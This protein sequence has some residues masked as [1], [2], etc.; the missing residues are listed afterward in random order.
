MNRTSIG[1]ALMTA[2]ALV[3]LIVATAGP[4]AAFKVDRCSEHAA[5]CMARC[6]LKCDGDLTKAGCIELCESACFDAF[7]KCAINAPMP[8]GSAN[9]NTPP[10]DPTGTPLKGGLKP[11]TGGGIK[12]PG[13][14][15]S[16]PPKPIVGLEPINPSGPQKSGDGG[17]GPGPTTIYRTHGK[18]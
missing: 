9:T 10:T 7:N 13:S 11:I 4:A 2:A 14:G 17:S 16:S 1:I 6:D 18:R 5:Q 8:G 15:G 3:V 12:D